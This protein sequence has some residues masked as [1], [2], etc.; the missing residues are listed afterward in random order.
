MAELVA[1]REVNKKTKAVFKT[2]ARG[3]SGTAAAL[4]PIGVIT[5]GMFEQLLGQ[6]CIS[7]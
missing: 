5:V 4:I 1:D 7:F 3:L 6:C 2:I